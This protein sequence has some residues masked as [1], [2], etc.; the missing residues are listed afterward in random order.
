MVLGVIY[1]LSVSS[2][3][4]HGL[5]IWDDPWRRGG[6]LLAGTGILALTVAVGKGGAFRRRLVVEVRAVDDEPADRAYFSMTASG[7]P[8]GGR[9]ELTYADGSRIDHDAPSGQIADYPAFRTAT[10]LRPRRRA[11]PPSTTSRCGSTT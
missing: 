6:A 4:F 8:A 1:A 3:F 11:R 10:R 9:V 2:V 5:V 7:Q